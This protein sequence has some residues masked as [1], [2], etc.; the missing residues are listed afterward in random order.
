MNRLFYSLIA[1]LASCAVMVGCCVSLDEP[2]PPTPDEP[3]PPISE[4]SPFEVEI[5]EITRASL[6]FNVIP[7]NLDSEYLCIVE[8][9]S[10]VDE[11]TKDEYLISTIYQ[12]IEGEANAVGKTL[13]EYLPSLTDKG[14]LEDAKFS[15]LDIDTE[16]YLIII[17]VDPANNYSATKDLLKSPFRTLAAEA[18]ECTFDVSTTVVDNNVT[19]GVSPSDK[20][21]YWYLM[22]LSASDYDYYVTSEQGMQLSEYSLFT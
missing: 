9:K 15:G 10:V 18:S 14:I 2:Q 3:Q 20:D 12:D 13:A 16:Y 17:G 4:E 6:R 5:V 7:T 1:L 8:E 21:H 11:F 19:F 22:T